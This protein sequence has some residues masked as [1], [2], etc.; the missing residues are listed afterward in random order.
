MEIVYLP[1][2]NLLYETEKAKLYE[3]RHKTAWVAKKM[4]KAM[5]GKLKKERVERLLDERM[6]TWIPKSVIV[7]E[8]GSF[9]LLK[10]YKEEWGEKVSTYCEGHIDD[11]VKSGREYK[12]RFQLALE[13]AVDI[14]ISEDLSVHFL[15]EEWRGKLQ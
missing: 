15:E 2:K 14:I 6:E 11:L 4:A 8:E 5:E 10:F 1:G 12:I 7:S 13:H 3:F 9:L